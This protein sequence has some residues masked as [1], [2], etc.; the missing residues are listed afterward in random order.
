LIR[1]ALAYRQM[2]AR[3]AVS[4]GPGWEAGLVTFYLGV[5]LRQKINAAHI[6]ELHQIDEH[7]GNFIGDPCAGGRIFQVVTYFRIVNPPQFCSKFADFRSQ[8]QRQV[9]NRVAPSPAPGHSKATQAITEDIEL[10][11]HGQIVTRRACGWAQVKTMERPPTES[12][13]A[14]RPNN[15]SRQANGY[16]QT[17]QSC[18]QMVRGPLMELEEHN[19]WKIGEAVGHRGPHRLQPWPPRAVWDDQQVPSYFILVHADCAAGVPS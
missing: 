18:G 8:G 5:G 7:V 10:A 2:G 11:R 16:G 14:T 3:D 4:L 12:L 15:L 6:S 9:T 13:R 1:G 17:R 19:C